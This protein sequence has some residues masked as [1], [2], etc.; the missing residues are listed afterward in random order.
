MP[1]SLDADWLK[2]FSGARVQPA[3]LVR[4][5]GGLGVVAPDMSTHHLPEYPAM[6]AVILGVS[7]VAS[8]IDPFRGRGKI[9]KCIVVLDGSVFTRNFVVNT[10]LKGRQIEISVGTPNLALLKFA[11]TFGGQIENVLPKLDGTVELVCTDVPGLMRQ[12][13]VT[14]HWAGQHPVEIASSIINK[15][16]ARVHQSGFVFD[17]DLNTSHWVMGRGTGSI[18]WMA[19]NA[20]TRP[21]NALRLL[22]EIAEL[23]PGVLVCREDGALRYVPFSDTDAATNS[24]TEDDILG[25]FEIVDLDSNICNRAEVVYLDVPTVSGDGYQSCYRRDDTESQAAHEFDGEDGVICDTVETKW[26]G[27]QSQTV[28]NPFTS[29]SV[30]GVGDTF[31]VAGYN[32]YN[33]CGAHATAGTDADR[34]LSDDRLAYLKIGAYTGDPDDIEVVAVDRCTLHATDKVEVLAIDSTAGSVESVGLYPVHVT[35]R[36]QERGALGSVAGAHSGAAARMVHDVTIAVAAAQRRVRRF[37]N[38]APTIAFSTGP[39]KHGVQVGD[40]VTVT[41]S[42]YFAYG[43]DGLDT[44][45]TWQVIAKEA[46]F[47]GDKP[48][49]RWRLCWLNY[50]GRP[51]QSVSHGLR[52]VADPS[53]HLSHQLGTAI[54]NNYQ[55][56]PFTKEGFVMSSP[57]GLSLAVSQ[58]NAVTWM[59]SSRTLKD[60]ALTMP[61]SKDTYVYFDTRNSQVAHRSVA[62]GDPAPENNDSEILLGKVVTNG[63]GIT[64]IDQ[65]GKTSVDLQGANMATLKSAKPDKKTSNTR[66]GTFSLWPD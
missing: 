32:V 15:T 46:D 9:S 61:A 66:N 7:P 19:T 56:K 45:T 35:Y 18:E 49:I 17:A 4:I 8:E 33:F 10:V 6:P 14:G 37:A 43:Q 51:V 63:S 2:E 65:S 64:S 22:D 42:R 50:A 57:S 28:G 30:P 54:A 12:R 13:S 31:S 58:G 34:Q 36:V 3:F 25:D 53:A 52:P 16:G 60:N 20:V 44:N 27:S 39:H 62:N 11:P 47:S 59:G 24:F 41:T 1:L 40:I 23:L 38:G 55:M 29:D 5:A 21:T 26:L 48:A